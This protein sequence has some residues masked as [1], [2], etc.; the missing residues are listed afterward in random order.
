[1]DRWARLA[2]P[3]LKAND[4]SHYSYLTQT[5]QIVTYLNEV[6]ERYQEA[7]DRYFDKLLKANPAPVDP[8]IL[9]VARHRN[10]LM[11]QARELATEEV[12]KNLH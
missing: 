6:S 1:M 2:E 5:G 3:Y 10:S 9:I 12:L 4:P 11:E 8:N 7:I